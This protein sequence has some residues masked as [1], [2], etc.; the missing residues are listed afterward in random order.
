MICVVG[1][2]VAVLSLGPAPGGC[3]LVEVLMVLLW[4]C[5]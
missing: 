1:V 4:D 2:V 3:G 5:W